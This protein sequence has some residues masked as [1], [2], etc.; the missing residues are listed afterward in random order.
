[1]KKNGVLN[2]DINEA[3]GK[4]GH[5]DAVVIADCGLPIPENTPCVDLALQKG[6]PSFRE[7]LTLMMD[8]MEIE[9][10]TLAEEIKAYNRTTEEK[11]KETGIEVTYISHDELKAS[12]PEA[13]LIIRTGEA[14][15]FSNA[16]LRSGV[17]F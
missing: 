9:T 3:L 6:V 12:L 1:M 5:T 11:V 4:L 8:E 2:R 14:T 10:I 17:I 16:I 7:V 15:P 13:R